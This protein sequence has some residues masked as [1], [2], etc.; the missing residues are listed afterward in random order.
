M[1]ENDI[2]V[3]GRS[4]GVVPLVFSRDRASFAAWWESEAA[5]EEIKEALAE[6]AAEELCER[7]WWLHSLFMLV[8]QS[9]T[10]PIEW[11]RVTGLRPGV[12]VRYLSL[13]VDISYGSDG[14]RDGVDIVLNLW[15]SADST[16]GE[17]VWL[18]VSVYVDHPCRE[19]APVSPDPR[20]A[21]AEI[22]DWALTLINDEV[23]RR[24]QFTVWAR[25]SMV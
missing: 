3:A 23:A 19:C 20:E 21:L 24:D 12:E 1:S 6:I 4:C 10:T 22:I 15:T 18:T 11:L 8:F 16:A 7:D 13:D 2:A 9:A 25:E 14:V 5:C 17:T